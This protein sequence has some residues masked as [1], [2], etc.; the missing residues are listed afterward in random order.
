[1]HRHQNVPL[2]LPTEFKQQFDAQEET[3][4]QR[5]RELVLRSNVVFDCMEKAFA[6]GNDV[7]N[8]AQ[9][10]APANSAMGMA[11]PGTY[12]VVENDK[13]PFN[14]PDKVDEVKK[15]EPVVAD[16][17][18]AVEEPVKKVKSKKSKG[19]QAVAA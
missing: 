8:K 16:K 14:S 12:T 4:Y 15:P 3:V 17:P 13:T 6:A 11:P 9:S 7:M 1:M 18:A 19:D 10:M 2:I 5:L